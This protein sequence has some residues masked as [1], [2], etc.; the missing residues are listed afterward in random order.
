MPVIRLPDGSQRT[1]DVPVSVADV[2]MSIGAG[3]AQSY[4]WYQQFCCLPCQPV[5]L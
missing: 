3:L 4:S 1:F 5:L 2:A